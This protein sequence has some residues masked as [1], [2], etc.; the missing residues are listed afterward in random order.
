MGM[1]RIDGTDTGETTEGRAGTERPPADLPGSEDSLS[2]A[3]SRRG[4]LAANEKPTPAGPET[5]VDAYEPEPYAKRLDIP[6]ADDQPTPREILRGFRP[7]EAGLPEIGEGRAAEY[8]AENADRRPWLA[9]AKDCDPAAMRVLVAMDM[10]Q[11]HAL[12]RHEG[13]ADDERL[14]RRVTGFQDPAQLDDAKRFAG[15]DGLK[16]GNR[17]HRCADTA[18][19]IQDPEAFATA[20][21]R[22]V[23]HPSV[24]DALE[25]PFVAGKVPQ[26]VALTVE[27]L[28]G[29]GG[30]R[31]CSA[32]ALE[33]VDG[34][35]DEALRRR[36]DWVTAKRT[37]N[38][39]SD[40]PE[41]TCVPVEIRDDAKIK[42]YFRPNRDMNG[43]E[44]STMYVEP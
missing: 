13:H 38:Q 9:Q 32:Y 2:R 3:E 18:T 27:D 19:A 41:P 35:L 15:I 39:D 21:A 14:Q 8:I 28:L 40:V 36:A 37:S 5:A 25:T 17:P 16:P 42:F 30:H 10:G 11:G 34:S 44:I 24:R 31:Y 12:E 29:V 7:T 23:R 33:P 26:G 43:Y 6:I 1:D 22:G 4:A 20:F